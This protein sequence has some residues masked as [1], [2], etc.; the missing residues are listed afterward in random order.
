MAHSFYSCY[1]HMVFSSKNRTPFLTAENSREIFSYLAGA[2]QNMGCHCLLVGGHHEHVHLLYR[3]SST[4]LTMDLVKE[5]K[6]QSAISL[7]DQ[8]LVV[9]GFSW[10]TGYGAFSISHWDVENI[11][12]YIAN[13]ESHHHVKSW[14][15]E[16]RELLEKHG[17]EYDERFF[18]G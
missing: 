7:K 1:E 2:I 6:R 16:L 4:I 9:P 12:H 5:L 14:E 13:Q 18:L 15:E 17:V 11:R 10:Q 3:K 8:G